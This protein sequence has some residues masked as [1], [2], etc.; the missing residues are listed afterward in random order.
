MVIVIFSGVKESQIIKNDEI[1]SI[2]GDSAQA[3][4]RAVFAP[5]RRSFD[6][7]PFP[8]RKNLR[9]LTRGKSSI[10]TEL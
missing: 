1:F 5:L 4:A 10:T 8:R 6:S 9:A 7:I 2:V 3:D